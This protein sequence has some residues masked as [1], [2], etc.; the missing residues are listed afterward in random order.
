MAVRVC[1]RCLA[2]VSSLDETWLVRIPSTCSLIRDKVWGADSEGMDSGQG[3]LAV[4]V[5]GCPVRH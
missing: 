2:G 4:R 5:E 3:R 1:A